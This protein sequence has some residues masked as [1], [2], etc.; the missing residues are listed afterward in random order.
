MVLVEGL[1]LRV[2]GSWFMAYGSWFD[3]WFLVSGFW[4]EEAAVRVRIEEPC[5]AVCLRVWN[6]V[7]SVQ[8][9]RFGV[10]G[11]GGCVQCFVL[12]IHGLGFRV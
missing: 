4:L 2:E 9:S 8:D 3:C 6:S 1:G 7:C 12:R 5:V 10:W 11:S